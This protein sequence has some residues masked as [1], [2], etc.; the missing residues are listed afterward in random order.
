[1]QQRDWTRRNLGAWEYRRHGLI[2]GWRNWG[3]RLVHAQSYL[4][5]R[6]HPWRVV[7]LV[8][9]WVHRFV[10]RRIRRWNPVR[11]ERTGG[12]GGT[13]PHCDRPIVVL[14]QLVGIELRR[15]KLS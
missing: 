2:S 3:S 6:A 5:I 1:M 4:E 10:V 7:A 11:H 15:S 13:K 8:L 9:L 12:Q 14:L